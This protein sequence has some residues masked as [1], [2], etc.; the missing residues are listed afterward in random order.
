MSE[1]FQAHN[2]EETLRWIQER[3]SQGTTPAAV[4]KEMMPKTREEAFTWACRL[5]GWDEY[6]NRFLAQALALAR[7]VSRR[8]MKE[9]RLMIREDGRV[10]ERPAERKGWKTPPPTAIFPLVIGGEEVQVRYTTGYFPNSGIDD[11]YFVSPHGPPQPHPLSETGYFS[12]FVPHDAVE[13]CGGPQAYAALLAEAI[14]RG[15]DQ[16]FIEA[17]EGPL[18]VTAPRRYR[19]EH[20]PAAEPGGQAERLIAEEMKAQALPQQGML[21]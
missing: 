2:Q 10:V 4:I 21:F 14:L 20:R 16:P 19:Q 8:V 9:Y 18:P 6:Q 1:L 17:F 15:E 12:R 3:L 5:P 7:L 11:L 13:A